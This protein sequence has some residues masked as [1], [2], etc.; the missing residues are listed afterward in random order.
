[1]YAAPAAATQV[2]KEIHAK[3]NLVNM[4]ENIQQGIPP[5][6]AQINKELDA[7]K[8]FLAPQVQTATSAKQEKVLNDAVKLVEA[9]QTTLE[10]KNKDEKIQQLATAIAT[11]KSADFDATPLELRDQ[12]NEFLDG[13][14]KMTMLFINSADYRKAVSEFMSLIR[15]MLDIGSEQIKPDTQGKDVMDIS[16]NDTKHAVQEVAD[17]ISNFDTDQ[18]PEDRKRA[19][20]QHLREFL[21]SLN[22]EGIREGVEG[23]INMWNAISGNMFSK[24]ERVRVNSDINRV[25]ATAKAVVEEFTGQKALDDWLVCVKSVMDKCDQDPE[26]QNFFDDVRQYF[27]NAIDKPELVESDHFY[28][29]GNELLDRGRTIMDKYRHDDMFIGIFEKARMLMEEVKNDDALNLLKNRTTEFFS[30]FV[31]TDA[32]NQPRLDLEL[33]DKLRSSL[34]PFIASRIQ[35]IPIR[36]VEIKDKDYEWLIFD[37]LRLCVD[38]KL[39]PEQIKLHFENYT[40]L[41]VRSEDGSTST[42]RVSFSVSN[43]KPKLENFYFS[44]KKISTPSLQDEGRLS[45]RVKGNGLNIRGRFILKRDPNTGA[46]LSDQRMSV[47]IDRLDIDILKAKH[48]ILLNLSTLFFGGYIKRRV[49][50][51]IKESLM[52]TFVGYGDVLNAQVFSKFPTMEGIAQKGIEAVRSGIPV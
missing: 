5:T 27:L 37:D 20:K 17:N 52:E 15:E 26:L 21:Q 2:P 1:M 34:I 14:K 35:E 4:A 22:Q 49:E 47:Q 11:S 51:Y 23:F 12:V 13:L 16:L 3:S 48:D 38:E 50:E 10:M 6:N 7:T 39:L 29:K 30:N 40:D 41:S 45:A 32:W 31:Y 36:R 33:L 43:L 44:M 24:I 28:D 19:F 18:I 25:G 46:L 42:T 9:A 8:Q